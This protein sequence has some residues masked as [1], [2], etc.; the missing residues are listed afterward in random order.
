MTAEHWTGGQQNIAQ[1]QT[2][3]GLCGKMTT[4]IA[5][6]DSRILIMMTFNL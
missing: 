5:W 6:E 3:E 1:Q 4:I 2:N